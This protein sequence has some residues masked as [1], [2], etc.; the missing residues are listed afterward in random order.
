MEVESEILYVPWISDLHGIKYT[1]SVWIKKQLTEY[2][3]LNPQAQRI[4]AKKWIDDGNRIYF[5]KIKNELKFEWSDGHFTNVCKSIRGGIRNG[6][7]NGLLKTYKYNE[8]N[9]LL[10]ADRIIF[11]LIELTLIQCS[12]TLDTVSKTLSVS[13]MNWGQCVLFFAFLGNIALES[14]VKALWNFTAPE[15]GKFIVSNI[16]NN[17]YFNVV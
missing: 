13:C 4:D 10:I 7:L 9:R 15:E 1:K 12:E 16:S 17:T 11:L 3:K 14:S 5:E 6:I 2:F 8:H